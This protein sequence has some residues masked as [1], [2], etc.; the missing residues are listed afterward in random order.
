MLRRFE[1]LLRKAEVNDRQ[2]LEELNRG[3]FEYREIEMR[4]MAGVNTKLANLEELTENN[5]QRRETPCG[6]KEI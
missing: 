1:G 4:K 2:A 6:N 3:T 5:L